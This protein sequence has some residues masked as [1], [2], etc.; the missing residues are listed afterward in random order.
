M[1]LTPSLERQRQKHGDLYEFLAAQ[2]D[3]AS[4]R[5]E[6]RGEGNRGRR[7]KMEERRKEEK[8]SLTACIVIVS[9]VLGPVLQ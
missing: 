2:W 9:L 3:P 7:G 4:K 1:S 6:R 8:N 5:K